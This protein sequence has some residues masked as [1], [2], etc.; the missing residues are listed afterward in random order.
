MKPNPA[1]LTIFR[2]I[3]G[4][5]H[6]GGYVPRSNKWRCDLYNEDFYN[7]QVIEWWYLPEDDTGN[8]NS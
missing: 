1:Q 2:T 3:D 7:D 8:K 6:V 4:I 5:T